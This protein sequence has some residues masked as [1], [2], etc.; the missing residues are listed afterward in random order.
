MSK[1]CYL[2][3]AGHGGMIDG[4]Y[5]TSGKRSPK[6]E[7]KTLIYEG[8]NN[9]INAE[10]LIEE[11]KRKNIK[12]EYLTDTDDDISLALRVKRANELSAKKKCI[13][14]SIHSNA[15]GNGMDWAN[16]KGIS[17]HIAKSHSSTTDKFSSVLYDEIKSEFQGLTKYRGIRLNDF[18]VVRKTNCP[19]VLCEYGFHDNLEEAKLMLTDDWRERLVNSIVNAITIFESDI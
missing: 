14:I 16:A 9:R 17:V 8:V 4:V 11:F 2:I 10:L 12:Y 1:Y 15:A 6:Y 18:Y 19:A 7:G 13:Y 3:D 5:Q